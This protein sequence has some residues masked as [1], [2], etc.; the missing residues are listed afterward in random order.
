MKLIFLLYLEDDEP[1]VLR[2]LEEAGV[3]TYSR[4]ELE[5]HG[6]GT[7]GWY[8][9]VP[10]YHS[11]MIFSVLPEADARRVLEAV[12]G[13]RDCADPRHPIHAMMVDIER[14]VRSGGQT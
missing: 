3:Q 8:G 12:E 6:Q 4:L 9:E 5:G 7:A 11:S 13:C 2:L 10:P 14:A 1:T